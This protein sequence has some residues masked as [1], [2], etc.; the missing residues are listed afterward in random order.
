MTQDK[1]SPEILLDAF[2]HHLEARDRSPHSI[3][4]YLSDLRQFA[5]W[6]ADHTG[7]PFTLDAVTEY[8]VRDWRDHL[9]AKTK[10]ATVNRKLA[11][12]SALYRWAGETG[13]T[14]RDPTRYVNGVAQQPTAPKALS[15][16]ALRR[17]LRQARRSGKKRDVALLELL[18]ATGLRASEVA[19]LT[20]GDLE[21]N[22]RSGWVTVRGKGRKQ[23]RVPVHARARRALR[24][25]LEERGDDVA[26]DEPLFLSQ[27]GGPITPYAVWYTV[28]KYARLAGV[29]DV[30]PHTFR[31]TVATRLVRDPAVDLVT[32]ATFLGHARLDT[33]A[34][35][36]RPS[37]EDLAEA[38]E[39]LGR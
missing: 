26:P 34:R 16:Q 6:F 29:E 12:L 31:H 37:E 10:P 38:A 13:R 25:Y 17:I 20:V 39:R 27:K 24:E 32:A 22:E 14:D 3:R 8:D 35:Y 1:T 33:T 36:S 7:E 15:D 9:A 28:K 21:L 30:S 19:G 2:R 5:A 23:R 4:A 11:A 18:A